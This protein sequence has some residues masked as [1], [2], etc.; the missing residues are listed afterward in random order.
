LRANGFGPRE[1]GAGPGSGLWK[2]HTPWTREGVCYL[3]LTLLF[4]KCDL[5]KVPAH[6][7]NLT[8]E[9]VILEKNNK[10]RIIIIL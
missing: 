1:L 4:L 7:K 3:T 6:V 9:A 5:Q 10:D 8:V 2:T